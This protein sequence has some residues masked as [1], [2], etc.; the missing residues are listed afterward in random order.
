MDFGSGG[1]NATNITTACDV[2]QSL[3][4]LVIAA[5][6][7][8]MALF[9]L[10]CCLL[11]VLLIIFFKRYKYLIQR[12]V[13]YVCIAA[14]ANSLSIVI[15]K[16][17]YFIE[18]EATEW[19]CLFAGCFEL[20]TSL[21]ELFALACISHS[22]SYIIRNRKEHT[23]YLEAFYI[24]IC[25][26]F[27]ALLS[28]PPFLTKSYGKS[29]P[30]C[31]IRERNTVCQRDIPG[32][33][34]QFGL[35]YL[36][37]ML[38]STTVTF[39]YLHI[40]FKTRRRTREQSHWKG[41]Y[42]PDAVIQKGQLSKLVKFMMA[43]MPFLYLL[44]NLFSLPNSIHWAIADAPLF[45]LWVMA[46]VLPPLRGALFALP[47]LFRKE[48]CKVLSRPQIKAAI[49][50]P[51][52][53]APYPARQAHFSDSL[54]FPDGGDS[55]IDRQKPYRNPSVS[56]VE[57][58]SSTTDD[59]KDGQQ[60]KTNFRSSGKPSDYLSDISE[61]TEEFSTSKL[62]TNRLANTQS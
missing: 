49:T 14:A 20:Y 6:R 59:K 19:Y 46:A 8:I 1:F 62:I 16:V 32:I 33:A 36:P 22:L 50:H 17:D 35:W 38:V 10:I 42:H 37:L 30:W 29:G 18:N 57:S 24:I 58:S 2:F 52:V 48:T 54:T 5:V 43:Y 40:I 27:P 53:V 7:A 61:H 26:V 31:W 55:T 39:V 21:M 28:W 56:Y 34:L 9:S 4:Y 15:Q 51:K 47:Y 12:M 23:R 41:P 11:V 13:L 44:V 25:L 60:E 3:E 45:P